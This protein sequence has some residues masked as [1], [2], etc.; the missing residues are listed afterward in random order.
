MVKTVLHLSGTEPKDVYIKK[1]TC[2]VTS[3]LYGVA[4]VCTWKVMWS[5]CV[6]N[7]EREAER[8][9]TWPCVCVCVRVFVPA[10][11][12]FEDMILGTEF[13]HAICPCIWV[14]MPERT[15][16]CQVFVMWMF[17]PLNTCACA[18]VSTFLKR[19]L[20]WYCNRT[21]FTALSGESERGNEREM[22]G[23]WGFLPLFK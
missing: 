18:S 13:L 9:Q 14:F 5:S 4:H 10:H 11:A 3:L 2:T 21:H 17:C 8:E 7:E 1:N 20:W 22:R 19:G 16:F 6:N 15:H 12:W 23:K